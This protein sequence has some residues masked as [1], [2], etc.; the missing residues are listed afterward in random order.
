M[1]VRALGAKAGGSAVS[2]IGV[3]APGRAIPA[4]LPPKP[5]RKKPRFGQ[6]S[7]SSLPS[8]ARALKSARTAAAPILD[9]RRTNR[10]A[11]AGWKPAV[12]DWSG[13]WCPSYQRGHLLLE[14]HGTRHGAG[15]RESRP[16]WRRCPA[17]HRALSESAAFDTVVFRV[18]GGGCRR[19]RAAED[20]AHRPG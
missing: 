9:L 7:E 1:R 4:K 11:C 2:G 18:L 5:L 16:C 10:M 17:S 15:W 20:R 8:E 13:R 12:P 3:N 14:S 6:K 19:L